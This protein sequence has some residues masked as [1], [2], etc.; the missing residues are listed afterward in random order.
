MHEPDGLYFQ[1]LDY[2][3]I[4]ER[5]SF[6]RCAS[7][8]G[9][10]VLSTFSFPPDLWLPSAFRG[11]VVARDSHVSPFTLFLAITSSLPKWIL[12]GPASIAIWKKNKVVIV[13]TTGIWVVYLAFVVQG[14]SFLV[15]YRRQIVPLTNVD[16]HQRSPG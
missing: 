9:N 3:Y 8:F 6:S 16:L 13:L 14:R 4:C 15:L 10:V 11:F 12:K 5:I 1:A 7:V 2:F